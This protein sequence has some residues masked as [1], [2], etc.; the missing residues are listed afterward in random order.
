MFSKAGTHHSR[1]V[2]LEPSALLI[3]LCPWHSLLP[4][5]CFNIS[6]IWALVNAL[7]RRLCKNSISPA[8]VTEV[9]P[10]LSVQGFPLISSSGCIAL[11][12]LVQ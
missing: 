12:W 8:M 11:I 2:D 4:F 3:P 5:S 6:W 9:N 1:I 7:K 10:S